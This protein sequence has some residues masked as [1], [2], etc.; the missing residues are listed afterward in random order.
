[1]WKNAYALLPRAKRTER[2]RAVWWTLPTRKL[3]G[4]SAC[5]ELERAHLPA[6]DVAVAEHASAGRCEVAVQLLKQMRSNNS[7][8]CADACHLTVAACCSSGHQEAALAVLYDMVL[9]CQMPPQR[10]LALLLQHTKQLPLDGSYAQ[11]DALYAKLRKWRVLGEPW[12]RH[13]RLTVDLHEHSV[14]LALA[15]VRAILRDVKHAAQ[16]QTHDSSTAASLQQQ[17][18][19]QQQQLAVPR[20][21]RIGNLQQQTLRIVTGRGKRSARSHSIVQQRVIEMLQQH[22]SVHCC[23]DPSNAGRVLVRVHDICEN[24][25]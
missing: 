3:T 21:L 4:Q 18:Q 22:C 2:A 20:A 13:Q 5:S 6:G 1:M 15:A 11:A 8:P 16:L 9:N 14:Q 25:S 24:A 17:Q 7:K 23:V 10:T 19:Q 12:H